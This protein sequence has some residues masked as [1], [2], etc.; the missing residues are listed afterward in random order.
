MS[1]SVASHTIEQT[2]ASARYPLPD[3]NP[4]SERQV[5]PA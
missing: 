3:G 4:D 1:N 5:V 2:A